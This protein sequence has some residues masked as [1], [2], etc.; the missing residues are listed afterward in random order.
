MALELEEACALSLGDYFPD[1]NRRLREIVAEPLVGPGEAIAPMPARTDV[2]I[3]PAIAG[4]GTRI[5]TAKP[6]RDAGAGRTQL[7]RGAQLE[8][9]AHH[10]DDRAQCAFSFSR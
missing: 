10:L 4:H 1:G 3:E 8:V 5:E 9:G 7:I 6:R 2:G